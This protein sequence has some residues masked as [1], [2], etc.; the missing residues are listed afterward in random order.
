[1]KGNAQRKTDG[2]RAARPAGGTPLAPLER[3]QQLVLAGLEARVARG[4][5]GET[6]EL[7]NLVTELGERPVIG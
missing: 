6:R 3:E 5:F 4:A 7:P 1:V 2:R